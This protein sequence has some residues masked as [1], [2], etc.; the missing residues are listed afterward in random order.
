MRD[1]H[2]GHFVV[3]ACLIA[4]GVLLSYVPKYGMYAMFAMS[5]IALVTTTY[6]CVAGLWEAK[7]SYWY[8]L[9]AVIKGLPDLTP[10]EK[11][12]LKLYAPEIGFILQAGAPVLVLATGSVCPAEFFIEYLD[13]SNPQTTWAKRDIEG[14]DNNSREVRRRMHDDLS[15]HLFRAGY[16]T[17]HPAGSDSW[18][19]RP[20][21]WRELH[22]KFV[23]NLP[24]LNDVPNGWQ[25]ETGKA[26]YNEKI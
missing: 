21:G 12:A 2:P 13:K 18:M 3:P 5:G 10:Q 11:E 9:A 15:H 20:G 4:A 17:S 24:N 25:I 22:S 7:E 19:W 8:S 23:G 14:T 26:G 6:I 16:L 1:I